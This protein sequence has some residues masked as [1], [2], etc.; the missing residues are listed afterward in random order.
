VRAVKAER[1]LELKEI[2]G[3]ALDL[4]DEKRAAYLDQACGRN[5]EL[6]S[7]VEDML[8]SHELN[9]NF[10][11]TPAIGVL[12]GLSDS[13]D[14]QSWIGRTV[15]SYRVVEEIGHGGMGV[16][17]RAKD[18]RLGRDVA[19][20]FLPPE[21]AETAEARARFQ[22]EAHAASALNHPNICTI[23][24][25]DECSGYPFIA[26][27]LLKGRTLKEITAQGPLPID[28]LLEFTIQIADALDAAHAEGIV[29][30]DI[31]PSNIFITDRGQAKVLDFGLAKRALSEHRAPGTIEADESVPG[32]LTRTGA[33]MGTLSYMSPEQSRGEELDARTDIFS[34]GSVIYEM[35]TGEKAF[36]GKTAAIILDAILNRAP[37]P[38]SGLDCGLP[39]KLEEIISKALAKDRDLRYQHAAD[40]RGELQRLKRDIESGGVGIAKERSGRRATRWVAT[41]FAILALAL[42]GS[43]IYFYSHRPA[44]LGEKDTVVLADFLNSTGEPVFDDTLK[45][46]LGVELSQSP[47]LN[48]LSDQRVR[49]TLG[50]MGRSPSERLTSD[51]AREV[52]QRAQS[53]AVLAGSIANLGSDY[54]IGLTA[55][56]CLTGDVL[57]QE[58]VPA[59]SKEGVLAATDRAAISLRAKL[60]ESRNT[61]NKYSLPVQ[62]VTT[63][64]LE[65]L[66]A[67]SMGARMVQES[68]DATAIPFFKR[69]IE[70]DPKF[71]A[72]FTWLAAAYS[73]IGESGLASESMRKAY[74][75]RDRVSDRERFYISAHYYDMVTG[76]VEKAHQVY[77]LWSQA[78]PKDWA[79]WGNL[80][81]NEAALGRYDH[82]LSDVLQSLRLNPDSAACYAN[83]I[84]LYTV[85]GRSDDAKSAYQQALARKIEPPGVHAYL[86]EVAFLQD[87]TEE[88]KR[89]VAWAAGRVGAEDFLFSVESDTAAYSGNLNKARELS[90]RAVES[91][92]RNDQR[93]TAALWQ[94]NAALRE[95]EF[96]EA[97]AARKTM[98]AALALASN[99]DTQILSALVLA[100]TGDLTRAKSIA[101]DLSRRFP[102]DTLLNGY[103]LPTIRAAIEIQQRNP[104]RAIELLHAA[105]PYELGLPNPQFEVGGLLYPVYIRGQAYLELHR[106]Y[107]AAAEF[108]KLLAHRNITQNGPIGVLA[109]LGL[110]RA[111]AISNDRTKAR[112]GYQD[113]LGLWKNAD[114]E[115]P[116]L[117]EA[118]LQYAKLQEM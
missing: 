49:E 110:A 37:V 13:G 59:T 39:T 102:L 69:A 79:P 27:E 54:V 100:R 34:F 45:Q 20:K 108:Q 118:Q 107:E 19:L 87:D 35:A 58:Q 24:A 62:Q 98:A 60:G 41:G 101:D 97:T 112:A 10:L 113:F 66:K 53:R 65:A 5:A 46:A 70:L 56:D 78:Y 57:G 67:F 42:A 30:R 36:P 109:R 77:A 29:H 17:Y 15:G 80:A 26:M 3:G 11:E 47:Y 82:A 84:Q 85:L 8:R 64:S 106:G 73:N 48:I 23:Y 50:L 28:R 103:W 81:F 44:K 96:G 40:M 88:M 38:P 111:Y 25:V 72:A 21:I 90:R 116:I 43:G 55:T 86:Y 12:H 9:G 94:M 105:L 33:A 104:A 95:A 22:R 52:C 92:L 115:I 6:R 91:S 31:K 7:D 51:V 16:I 93:E 1:W 32:Q 71:A 18:L 2:V 89:Q 14:G 114:P 117:R 75:L 63:P 76:E 68:G 61:I 74:D 99:H 4:P 83:V